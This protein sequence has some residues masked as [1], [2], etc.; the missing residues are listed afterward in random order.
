V[1]RRGL[2]GHHP[3]AHR[4]ARRTA[5]TGRNLV[6]SRVARLLASRQINFN[7][8]QLRYN[9]FD[10]S[11]DLRDVTIKSARRESDPPFAF[12]KHLEADLSLRHLIRGR[13][14]VEA[15]LIEGARIHYLIDENG[16]NLPRPPSDPNAPGQEIDYLIA[17]LTFADAQVRY[18]NRVQRL[19]ATLPIMSVTVSGV[20][21][22]NRHAISVTANGGRVL[23]QG[24]DVQLAHLG[25]TSLSARTTSRSRAPRLRPKA[26][27]SSCAG[28]GAIRRPGNARMSKR[29]SRRKRRLDICTLAACVPHVTCIGVGIATSHVA[30][31]VRRRRAAPPPAVP[32][33][34]LR[35]PVAGNDECG[36]GRQGADSAAVADERRGKLTAWRRSPS[37]ARAGGKASRVYQAR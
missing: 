10:L 27:A 3:S 18:D 9:L 36:R 11:L 14:V 34:L 30:R 6:R 20:H 16:D 24:R 23:A 22:T 13:Y 29:R 37:S 17:R 1:A 21:A 28:S 35:R 2:P 31:S 5:H 4:G 12:I 19:D 8:E 25:P 32:R 26:R 33:R 7:A 15:G